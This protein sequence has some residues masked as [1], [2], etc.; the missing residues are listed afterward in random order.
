MTQLQRDLLDA[1][2]LRICKQ[3]QTITFQLKEAEIGMQCIK[4]IHTFTREAEEIQ[5][6][7]YDMWETLIKGL[8]P[9]LKNF[10]SHL[11]ALRCRLI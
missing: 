3:V 10:N 8:T 6:I 7:Q 5:R 1:E 4:D 11:S 9:I 2:Y